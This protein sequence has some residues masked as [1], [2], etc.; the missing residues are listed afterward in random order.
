VED[1][2]NP[3]PVNCVITVVG[4]VYCCI[5]SGR[6]GVCDCSGSRSIVIVTV[7]NV[8]YVSA[9]SIVDF[10]DSGPAIMTSSVLL[11]DSTKF[12]RSL[13]T[14]SARVDDKLRVRNVG[15][16]DVLVIEVAFWGIF[17]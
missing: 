6:L 10:A 9:S 16:G 15:Y 3:S 1:E 12:D 5:S 11:G 4:R 14:K 2:I 8:I 17:S 7:G 13:E